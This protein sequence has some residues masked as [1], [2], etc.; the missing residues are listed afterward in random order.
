MSTS[1]AV[2]SKRARTA[3]DTLA[4]EVS[5]TALM[6]SVGRDM[7]AGEDRLACVS[8]SG[9]FSGGYK[10]P[11]ESAR[12]YAPPLHQNLDRS[13]VNMACCCRE[14]FPSQHAAGR[15]LVIESDTDFLHEF[16]G[17]GQI[18]NHHLTRFVNWMSVTSCSDSVVWTRS[19]PGSA[20]GSARDVDPLVSIRADGG[21]TIQIKATPDFGAETWSVFEPAVMEAIAPLQTRAKWTRAISDTID[22]CSQMG[23]PVTFCGPIIGAFGSGGLPDLYDRSWPL[24][25]R[26]EVLRTMMNM[27]ETMDKCVQTRVRLAIK[28]SKFKCRRARRIISQ[29]VTTNL[30]KIKERLWHPEG[31]LMKRRFL[32]LGS[33]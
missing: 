22:T 2:R 19:A 20:P 8:R 10:S 16:R 14:L 33:A 9:H 21:V 30:H 31:A 29:F 27:T 3:A 11:G 26:S 28:V 1:S 32:A 17:M 15:W 25:P 18:V 24:F 13:D 6:S 12:Y 7:T 5:C 4:E 23:D